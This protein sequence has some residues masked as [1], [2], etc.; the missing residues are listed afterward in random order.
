MRKGQKFEQHSYHSGT[1]CAIDEGKTRAT[2][3]DGVAHAVKFMDGGA[4]W[5]DDGES[6]GVEKIGE[7]FRMLS[8]ELD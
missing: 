1:S 6:V 3:S 8:V 7:A 2:E 5:S 4:V